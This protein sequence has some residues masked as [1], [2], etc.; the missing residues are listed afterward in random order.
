MLTEK[1]MA[2]Y[3]AILEEELLLATGCTEPIAVAYCAAKL[4]AVL[5]GKPTEVDAPILQSR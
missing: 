1:K 4:R 2:D 3:M 5:G